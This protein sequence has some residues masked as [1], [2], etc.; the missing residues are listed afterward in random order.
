MLW[1]PWTMTP[2]LHY[3]LPVV[4]VLSSAPLYRPC[5]DKV[6]HRKQGRGAIIPL[7]LQR[8][9]LNVVKSYNGKR[10]CPS[11]H[12]VPRKNSEMNSHRCTVQK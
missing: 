5:R 6:E 1:Q 8:T 3:N 2:H 10:I 12:Y 11:F 7:Q 9:V 4:T